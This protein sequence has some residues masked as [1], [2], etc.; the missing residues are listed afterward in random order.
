MSGHYVALDGWRGIC[1]ILVAAHHFPAVSHIFGWPI[2]R[3][4]FLFVDYFFVLSGFVIAAAY[5]RKLSDGRDF[6]RFMLKRFGRIAPLHFATLAMIVF[7]DCALWGIGNVGGIGSSLLGEGRTFWE[8]MVN[9]AM[10]QSFGIFDHLTWNEPSWS[11]SAEFWVSSAFAALAAFSGRFAKPALAALAVAALVFLMARS[12]NYMNATGDYGAIRCM[13]GFVI[14]LFIFDLKQLLGDT[15]VEMRAHVVLSSA[16]EILL[17]TII[18]VFVARDGTSFAS[19]GAPFL[20]AAAVLVFSAE[21]GIVSW[22]LK[23]SPIIALGAWSYSI[24]MMHFVVQK[25]MIWVAVYVIDPLSPV[26]LMSYPSGDILFGTER[27]MGDLFYPLMLAIVIALSRLT[28]LWIEVP[29][30]DWFRDRARAI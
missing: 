1:A 13:V 7:A 24:Y 2:I 17:L 20:F 26:P 21:A 29:A 9:I 10:M 25:S 3:N 4:S 22:L 27:W 18:M 12:P 8:A 14:G 23:S 11:I 16:I 5:G 28:F 15:L 30:R 19:F 6:A